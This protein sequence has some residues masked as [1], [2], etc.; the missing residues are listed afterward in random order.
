[1][2]KK[3]YKLFISLFIFL[4]ALLPIFAQGKREALIK[5]SKQ[6]LGA[7]YQRGALGPNSFDCSGFIYVSAQGVGMQLPRTSQ[8]M[9]NFATS[10]PDSEREKG[11]LVFFKTTSSGNISHVGIYIGDN[12]FIHCASD[13]P[14]TGVI[15]SSLNSSYWK[16]HYAGS[17]RIFPQESENIA[18]TVN[19][20][21]FNETK[22]DS[23]APKPEKLAK[24]NYKKSSSSDFELDFG[25]SLNWS[26][27]TA[28]DFML[29]FRGFE[30]QANIRMKSLE[31]QPG[32]GA[33]LRYDSKMEILQL[34]ILFSL[35]FSD[36]LRAY[37]GPVISIGT[38]II[39]GTDEE[40][41]ASIFPGIIGL[42]LQTPS[43]QAGKF[44]MALMQDIHYTVFNDTDNSA[45]NPKKSIAS[46]LLFSTGLRLMLPL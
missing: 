23:P 35:N 17:G 15:I 9:Y 38:P 18:V 43:W 3:I 24:K 46:G 37:A 40:A 5:Y 2:M 29:N 28:K 11:D 34:P 21:N 16:N 25:T 10:I 13:G 19:E 1:M 44:R 12:K 14:E 22:N 6:F 41:K 33:M 36:Y 31:L 20:S 45:L 30:V 7:S 8:A 42:S 39:P 26:V 27:L 32:I 4:F